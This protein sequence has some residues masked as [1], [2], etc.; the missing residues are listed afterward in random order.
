MKIIKSLFFSI[1]YI[2]DDRFSFLEKLPAYIKILLAF[3]PIAYLLE[4][5][6]YWF[7]DNK[8]FVTFFLLI[9]IIQGAFGIWKHK[10]LN[11]FSWEEFF[12]KTGKML[13]IVIF[14][15]FLLS[16]VG[17]IASDNI[18]AEGFELSI[19]VMT[20]FFPASKGIKSIFIISNGEYPPKWMMKKVYNYEND[21]DLNDLFKKEPK[22][23]LKDEL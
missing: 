21:G 17:G 10:I 20:L 13:V 9:V 4:L 14:T 12:I 2:A 18:I 1:I 6:G 7:V 22:K 19:Q 11:Q 16:M 8:K 3:G 23:D 5:G 15:Y